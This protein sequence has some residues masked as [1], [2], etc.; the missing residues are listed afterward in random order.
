MPVLAGRC[1]KVAVPSALDPVTLARQQ[2]LLPG[3]PEEEAVVPDPVH[4][5]PQAKAVADATA[6]SSLLV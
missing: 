4:L 5:K 6:P 1:A 3:G 2:L